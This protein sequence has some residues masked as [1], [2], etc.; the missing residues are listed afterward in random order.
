MQNGEQL[1]SD[2]LCISSEGI[3]NETCSINEIFSASTQGY[4]ALINI[5]AIKTIL[6]N[7]I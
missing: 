4:T 6:M 3:F 5:T 1:S 2:S 7:F